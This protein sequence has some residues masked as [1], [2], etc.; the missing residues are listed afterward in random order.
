MNQITPM[1]PV[2]RE[3]T[4]RVIPMPKDSNAAGDVFGGWI[5]S[6]VDLAGSVPAVAH[7]KGRVVTVAVNEF[8]FKEPVFVGDLCSFYADVDKVGRTSMRVRVEVY[9]QR[10]LQPDN[11][12]KVTEAYITYVAVD[13]HR[14]PRPVEPLK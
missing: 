10:R 2:D 5:M 9:A 7:A 3:P 8:I 6:Q 4:I 12:A 13:E 14:N 11:V 1:L